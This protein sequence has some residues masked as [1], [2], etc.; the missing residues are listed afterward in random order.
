[1]GNTQRV[2]VEGQG[3]RLALAGRTAGNQIVEFD[4][5][6]TCIGTFVE[7]NITQANGWKLEGEIT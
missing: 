5:D 4:G 6:E 1:V 7:V 3:K 2:L